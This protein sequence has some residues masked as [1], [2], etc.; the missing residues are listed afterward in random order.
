MLNWLNQVI[1]VVLFSLRTLPSRWGASV[2]AAVGIG[3]VVAVLVSV[4]AMAEGFKK[5]MTSTGSSD[6]AIVLRKG[7]DSE[8]NSGLTREE[9]RVVRDAPSIMPQAGGGTVSS[10]E[11]FVVINLPKRSTGTDANVPLRGVEGAAFELRGN[12]EMVEGR[13][14]EPGKNEIIVGVGAARAFAGLQLGNELAIGPNRWKVTGIFTAGGGVAESEIW[15]DAAVLMPVYMRDGFQSV[16][17]KLAEG[18]RF[19][20]FQDYL[21]ANKN[22]EAEP[23]MLDAFYAEQS[24]TVTRF[25]SK[26]GVGI[27]VMMALGALFGALNTMFGAVATRTR[28][29]AT[30]RALGFGASPVVISVLAESLVLSLF[31]GAAGAAAAFVV[32]DGYQASTMNWQTFSQ[33]TFAFAVTPKLLSQAVLWASVLGIL[34]GFFPAL[35]AA[36]LPIASA[37]RET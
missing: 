7:A 8:M 34:G 37:L 32:F 36:S 29:I 33:V 11:L 3:G 4:L 10:A 19:Q 9:A 35:R 20:D 16:Y 6:V 14:F 28:E 24:T 26:L 22:V 21:T 18:A 15:T 17:V 12:I 31:G 27:A 5:A 2:T 30:L 25:I 23:M 1:S 13:R